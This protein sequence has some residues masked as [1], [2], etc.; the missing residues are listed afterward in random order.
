MAHHGSIATRA[1]GRAG[2]SRERLCASAWTCRSSAISLYRAQAARR[3]S[4][5]AERLPNT[6]SIRQCRVSRTR[7]DKQVRPK[8]RRCDPLRQTGAH[9]G[10]LGLAHQELLTRLMD[11]NQAEWAPLYAQQGEAGDD[12]AVGASPAGTCR[13][14]GRRATASSFRQ[15]SGVQD[16]IAVM[17]CLRPFRPCAS[18]PAHRGGHGHKGIVP[19]PPRSAI[20]MQQ[21]H[22]DTIRISLTPEPAATARRGAGGAGASA[23]DGAP[24][25]SF[26]WSRP[27]RAGGRTTS[28]FQNWPKKIQEDIREHA[29]SGVS[30]YPRVER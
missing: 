2:R 18:S 21:G 24:V 3:S 12:R 14:A 4:A 19:L 23:G 27:V 20:L 7:R 16:L 22:G 1:R 5:C 9:R 13:G 26:R 17:R 30:K 29:R 8:S 15:V 10:E 28:T 6:A 11:A 25:S